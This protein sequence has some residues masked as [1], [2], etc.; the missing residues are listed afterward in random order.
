MA[1]VSERAG[2]VAASEKRETAWDGGRDRG[3]GR[4]GMEVPR[5]FST[6]G[7][8]PF[9][10]VDWELRTAEIKDERGRVDLPA[11]RLRGP[12]DLEPTGHERGGEQV[13]LRRRGQRQRQ[14]RGGQARVFGS[15]VDRPR[16]PD[17]RRLGQGRRL[18]RHRRGRRAVL[19]RADGALPEPV[20]VVQLAGLVQR[21]AVSPLRDFRAGQQLALGRGDPRRRQGHQCLPVSR[22]PRRAS[23]RASATTWKGSCGWRPARPCSSSSARGPAPTSRPCARAAKSS[24]AAASRRA[25]SA[26]CGSTTRSPAW[27]SQAARPAAPPRCRRSSAGTPT[28][29]SS[30]SAR[31]R[32]RR[33]P[34]R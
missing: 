18:F 34:R 32:R 2:I 29:S 6:E 3:R 1:T 12:A 9:D 25:R 27:S 11:D 16:D 20:R 21:G 17:D 31:P 10:Q 4:R 7:S 26:S 30:S 22:R 24:P 33:R 8:S 23:S 5:V 15:P 14:S 19:R 13:L 28:S